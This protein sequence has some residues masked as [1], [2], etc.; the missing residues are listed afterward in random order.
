MLLS[1]TKWPYLA[2]YYFMA[3]FAVQAV[4]AIGLARW[5]TREATRRIGD[6]RRR[7]L[8]GWMP[9]A[10]VAFV[11]GVLGSASLYL[12]S[13]PYKYEEAIVWGLAFTLATFWA[14]LRLYETNRLWYAVAAGAFAVLAFGSRPPLGAGATAAVVLFAILLRR[15]HALAIVLLV[16]AG[17]A[18]LLYSLVMQLK[19]HTFLAPPYDHNPVIA[20]DHA[21][22]ASVRAGT[23]GVR[24]LPTK[25]VQYLRPD[26][27][28]FTSDYPWFTWRMPY[29]AAVKIFG[30]PHY[31]GIEMTASITDTMPF[32]LALS[33][34]GLAVTLRNKALLALVAG[35]AI[36][37]L[38]TATFF[39]QTER[40]MA[41]FVPLLA[42]AAMG[43]VVAF[44]SW[45]PRRTCS[46]L[47][48]GVVLGVLCAWSLFIMAALT[49][50]Y[51]GI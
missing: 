48:A 6:E 21:R 26:T 39:G 37:A 36:T 44:L 17:A 3:A 11:V 38:V 4:A 22:L 51:S 1:P 41:D 34:V 19:F 49:G 12:A 31:D 20:A 47:I 14:L 24:Y 33:V 30:N 10:E 18:V 46:R 15:K 29:Y 50:Q 40:Y 43:G 28:H 23:N 42:V 45:Q 13:R 35:G 16:G 2:P 7:A 8:Q 25:V 27:L 9:A 5:C 32:L